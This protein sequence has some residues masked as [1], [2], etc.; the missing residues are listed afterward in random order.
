MPFLLFHERRRVSRVCSLF[1]RVLT[2]SNLYEEPTAQE[3][4]QNVKDWRRASS[5]YRN[6]SMDILDVKNEAF[7]QIS[8]ADRCYLMYFLVFQQFL[9][10]RLPTQFAS[11][12]NTRKIS[13]Q[14]VC[15]T[16]GETHK[17]VTFVCNMLE[18]IQTNCH[19]LLS[20]CCY[21]DD[22]YNASLMT[23]NSLDLSRN[24]LSDADIIAICKAIARRYHKSE[25]YTF[26][27]HLNLSGNADITDCCMRK[28]LKT[29]SAYC[30]F[31]KSIDIS[32]TSVSNQT[33][34]YIYRYLLNPEG[35]HR[36]HS[37]RLIHIKLLE[38]K[39]DLNGIQLLTKTVNKIKSKIYYDAEKQSGKKRK[40]R[41]ERSLR[42]Y[43]NVHKRR[44]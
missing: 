14:N 28:L 9:Y 19:P 18:F 41:R 26:L 13:L 15:K 17:V 35:E 2:R 1:H 21:L 43:L 20:N 32:G 27:K 22:H 6:S 7:H 4:Q 42:D 36:S 38:T 11:L 29:I 44:R 33:C 31:V 39:C 16:H 37:M 25:K 40:A 23:I 12:I 3:I 30:P 5:K 10:Q 24:Q 34:V 8:V